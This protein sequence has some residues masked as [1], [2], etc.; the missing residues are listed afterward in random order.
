MSN[1]AASKDETISI[2]IPG[3]VLESLNE[4]A[5]KQKVSLQTLILNC[6]VKHITTKQ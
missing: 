3:W 2:K 4:H 1:L 5:Q 6:V